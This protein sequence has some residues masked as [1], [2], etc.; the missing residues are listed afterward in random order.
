[1]FETKAKLEDV[2]RMFARVQDRMDRIEAKAYTAEAKLTALK[3]LLARVLPSKI[4][5]QEVV[6]NDFCGIDSCSGDT[7]S[8]RHFLRWY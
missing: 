1:M 5:D 3:Q 7:V 2:E 8:V 6:P 4:L